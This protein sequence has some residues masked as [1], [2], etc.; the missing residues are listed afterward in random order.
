MCRRWTP[1]SVDE[2]VELFTDD[3]VRVDHRSLGY[4]EAH[5][6]EGIREV[7]EAMLGV[8]AEVHIDPEEV[9]ACDDRVL[10]LS[11]TLR[12]TAAEGGGEFATPCGYL[13]VVAEGRVQRLEQFEP[14]DRQ[15]MIA[16]Y[17]ELGGGLGPL[18]DRPPERFLAEFFR[19]AAA[20]DV[21]GYTELFSD[22]YVEIDHR[23]LPWDEHGK[24]DART[25]LQGFMTSASDVRFEVEE[26][27]AC[28]DRAVA[29][30]LSIRGTSA[31]GGGPYKIA[32]CIVCVIEGELLRS[33]DRYGLDDRRA[34]LARYAE[35]V[36]EV[37]S[38]VSPDA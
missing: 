23:S 5:R 12:S 18:G 15:K 11:A 10:V 20:Q 38:A 17:A 6:R 30:S 28:D 2:L 35:L 3:V 25:R 16:R 9:L 29:M 14:D 8:S 37:G 27:L 36:G 26:V 1:A 32:Y 19:R 7:Y 22:Q 34:A 31:D 24:A 4:E 13:F 21:D 33:V